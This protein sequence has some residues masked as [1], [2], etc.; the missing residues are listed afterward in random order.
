[1]AAVTQSFNDERN[2]L[3]GLKF[4]HIGIAV[5]SIADTAA[6]YET[7]GYKKSSAIFDPIQNVNIC[8]LL[9][10]DMPTL[11]L[12]EPVDVM[13]PVNKTLEKVG[14]ISYHTCYIVDNIEDIA[15]RLH[16][17]HFAAVSKPKEA[18]AIKG[19][20]V[21]FFYS[22]DVGLIEVVETPADITWGDNDVCISE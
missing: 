19:S 6:F 11:E 17:L 13:S 16:K 10:Q 12:V 7:I 4:H 20:R 21:A 22:K 14:V 9:R 8:W 15:K 3:D 2:V 5:K 18:V 1:M